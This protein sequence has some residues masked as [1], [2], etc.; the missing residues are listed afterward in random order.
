LDSLEVKQGYVPG[1]IGE[2]SALHGKYYAQYWN[3]G[4]LFEAKVAG[5]IAEFFRRYDENRDRVWSLYAGERLA[6]S[7]TIDGINAGTKGAQVRWFIL[8]PEFQGQ[9]LGTKLITEAMAFC[10]SKGYNHIFLTTFAGLDAARHLYEKWGFQLTH[11]QRGST[12]GVALTEQVFERGV[13]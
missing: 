8:H 13:S 6:G 10:E 2:I 11:E 7:I 4:V 12:W 9:G 1:V 3:L 5:G